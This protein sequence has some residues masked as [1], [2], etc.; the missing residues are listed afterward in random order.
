MLNV[1]GGPAEEQE[2]GAPS[3][4]RQVED[5]GH[6]PGGI[7]IL[8]DACIS[9]H[10]GSVGLSAARVVSVACVRT[11]DG[12]LNSTLGRSQN[13]GSFTRAS[14]STV[15]NVS[16]GSTLTQG[17]S[18]SLS[19]TLEGSPPRISD[20]GVLRASDQSASRSFEPPSP[21]APD[22]LPPIKGT[23]N[24]MSLSQTVT[25]KPKVGR[26]PFPCLL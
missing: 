9:V 17:P 19:K 21:V 1:L 8:I 22:V 5:V 7:L 26:R 2:Q 10:R 4:G 16:M 24:P 15:V 18:A 6:R 14:D 11:S 20:G 23:R 3:R 13:E 12:G 25:V